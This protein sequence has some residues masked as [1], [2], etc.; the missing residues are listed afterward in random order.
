MANPG[1]AKDLPRRAPAGG[2]WGCTQPHQPV[3]S[4]V[5]SP[6]AAS[7]YNPRSKL[8]GVEWLVQHAG[9]LPRRLFPAHPPKSDHS[10]RR[11]QCK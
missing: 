9:R 5:V 3:A 10:R 2:L 1:C 7:Q 4:P 11:I 8:V 6:A